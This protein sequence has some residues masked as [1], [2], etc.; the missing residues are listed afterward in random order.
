[1]NEKNARQEVLEILAHSDTE[2]E[3]RNTIGR[4]CRSNDNEIDA[5]LRGLHQEGVIESYRLLDG[6][7]YALADNADIKQAKS[8]ISAAEL[9]DEIVNSSPVMSPQTTDRDRDP[10][11]NELVNELFTP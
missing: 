7:Y 2:I 6:T 3:G 4:K 9:A 1:M 5:A 10:E 8:R 11:L